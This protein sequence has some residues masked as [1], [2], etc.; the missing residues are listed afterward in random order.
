MVIILM[1]YPCLA[2]YT[3]KWGDENYYC[4]PVKQK[5]STWCFYACLSMLHGLAQATYA[6]IYCVEFRGESRIT[7][8]SN[9]FYHKV[10]T[11]K[12]INRNDAAAFMNK[13]FCVVDGV[14][15]G[16]VYTNI[17]PVTYLKPGVEYKQFPLLPTIGLEWVGGN[18]HAIVLFY[19]G[20]SKHGTK[21]ESWEYGYIE[22]WT[23][24]RK[25]GYIYNL[26]III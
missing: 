9:S 2:Q 10:C 16:G 8:C 26:E 23:G 6:T 11:D 18:Y 21:N 5:Y 15:Y 1:V 20:M 7:D 17:V 3:Y 4:P 19:I 14:T 25:F 12:G 24:M 13:L 22:P